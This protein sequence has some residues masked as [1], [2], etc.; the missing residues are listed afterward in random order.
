MEIKIG[1]HTIGPNHPTYFIADIAANHDGDLERAKMLIH[2]AKEAGADAAKFQNFKA[3]KIVSDYGFKAMSGGQ[4]SHQAAWKKSVFQ[5]Y[6]EASIPLGWTPTLVEECQDAGIDYFTSPY[7]FESI[8]AVDPYLPAYKIG[9]GEID[10][11]ESLELMASKGKPVIL[12]TGAANIGE[13][14]RAV[15]AILAINKQLVLLQCNTNYTASPDN[16]DYINLNVLKTYA[17]MFPDMVLGLSDHTHANATVLGAV[18]LGAR[19]IERHFTDSNDREGPDHKFAMNPQAWKSMVDETRLL[20]R[21]LGT[22]DKFIGGNEQD[23]Q[24]VQRRC[25]RAAREIKAGETF[26]RDMIDVLRPATPGAIKPDQIPNVIGTKALQD[27][28]YGKELR[29]TDLGA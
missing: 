3:P 21:A 15:H 24:V 19:V 4:V 10:W 9:S 8:E 12:A 28:P 5:V 20:E 11:I 25:L 14:Q 2:L 23:T 17:T 18:A 22:A 6:S 1:S 26:S 27:M 7:D 13:V 29:W 16:Y